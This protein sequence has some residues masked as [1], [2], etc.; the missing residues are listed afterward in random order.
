MHN[1]EKLTALEEEEAD[2]LE[3]AAKAHEEREAKAGEGEIGRFS[4]FS[5]FLSLGFL[6][7]SGIDFS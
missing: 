2:A 7:L 3:M 4:L 1:E 5:A 6:V